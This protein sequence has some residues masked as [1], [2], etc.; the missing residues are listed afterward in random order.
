MESTGAE[1][2]KPKALVV[3]DE[4]LIADTTGEILEDAGFDVRAAYDGSVAIDIAQTFR[5]DYLLTDVLMPRMNGVELA[6]AILEV[7]P[8]TRIVLFSGQ[9][10]IS[11]ILLKGYAL[12]YRFDL[13]AKPIHPDKL[14]QQLMR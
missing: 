4:R 7:S 12:G 1:P 3:D 8:G 10:G 11:E 13:V 2:V 6:I 5:P 14:I 9:A